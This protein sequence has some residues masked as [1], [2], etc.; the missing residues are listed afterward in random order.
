VASRLH[1]DMVSGENGS[2]QGAP[3]RICGDLDF[4]VSNEKEGTRP[5]PTTQF[6]RSESVGRVEIALAEFQL[7]A[8]VGLGEAEAA[9]ETVGVGS[10]GV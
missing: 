8:G 7:E 2:P 1:G 9:I 3:L 4:A 5:S 10:G 6:A